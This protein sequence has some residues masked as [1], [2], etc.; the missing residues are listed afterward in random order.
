MARDVSSQGYLTAG[1]QKL[2]ELRSHFIQ[3]LRR[4]ERD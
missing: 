3:F 2:E 4:K 1:Q